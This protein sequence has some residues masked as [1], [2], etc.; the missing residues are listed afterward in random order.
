MPV[1]SRGEIEL[2]RQIL[3][4]VGEESK[5]LLWKKYESKSVAPLDIY[6][7]IDK[8]PFKIS[9]NLM[10]QI[11]FWC[12]NQGS[13]QAAEDM[14]RATL[15]ITV[16]DDTMRQVTNYIGK[17]VFEEDQKRAD[18]AVSCLRKE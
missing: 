18:E 16:N 2:Y 13:Y 5:K 12:Q 8:L 15:G 6:L 7:G 1:P 17:L 3:I 10:L 11:V 14:I 4:P 9:P